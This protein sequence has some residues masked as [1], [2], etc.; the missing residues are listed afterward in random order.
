M[1]INSLT[2]KVNSACNA[3]CLHC[4]GRKLLNKTHNPNPEDI[5]LDIAETSMAF[6]K[7]IGLKWITFSGGEPTLSSSLPGLINV[8]TNYTKIVSLITNGHRYSLDYWKSLFDNGLK[9]VTVSLDSH[10]PEIHDWLRNKR[11]LHERALKTIKNIHKIKQNEHPNAHIF[12]ITILSNFN[13]INLDSLFKLLLDLG[14]S[15][16]IIHLPENDESA[17]FAPSVEKQKQFLNTTIPRMLEVLSGVPINKL[18]EHYAAKGI[19]SIL[20]NKSLFLQN[21]ARG[22]YHP[23]PSRTKCDVPGKFLLVK[24]NGI[25][26]ACNGGE[27]T[28]DSVIGSIDDE[29]TI[30][31]NKKDLNKIISDKIDYCKYCSVPWKSYIPLISKI[32]DFKI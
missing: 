17:I 16:W 24:N 6:S 8:A 12:I 31:I 27:Y 14:V 9:I 19:K 28:T 21:T 1:K 4:R 25:L 20:Y 5:S 11:G 26:H 22:V 13:I 2:I 29:N 3:G 18:I 15:L 32:A 30:D 23:I 7:A 10:D